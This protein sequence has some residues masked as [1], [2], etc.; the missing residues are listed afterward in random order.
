MPSRELLGLLVVA[1]RAVPFSA[2]P[3]T[4]T[5]MIVEVDSLGRRLDPPP[6]GDVDPYR[7]T[8]GRPQFGRPGSAWV[9]AR[10][11]QGTGGR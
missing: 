2:C 6:S 9:Y 1:K 4:Y 11:E 3:A 8:V 10:A 5:G 7:L